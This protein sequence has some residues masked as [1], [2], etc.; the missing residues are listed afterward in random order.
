MDAGALGQKMHREKKRKPNSQFF[1]SLKIFV[2][3]FARPFG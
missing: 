3:L 2:A 1:K